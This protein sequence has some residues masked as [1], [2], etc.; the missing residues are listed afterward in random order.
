MTSDTF[1][2]LPAAATAAPF[3]S[4]SCTETT[5]EFELLAR[6]LIDADDRGFDRSVG[7]GR[8]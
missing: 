6:G 1:P 2:P 3:P 4:A 7:D 5:T 8:G